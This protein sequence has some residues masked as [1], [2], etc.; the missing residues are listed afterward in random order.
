MTQNQAL[1][2]KKR[3]F[4]EDVAGYAFISPWLIC[5]FA[6]S[7]IPIVFSL[8]FSFTDYDILA[9][10]VF[11]GLKNFRRMA[12]DE[13]F[14]KSLAVTFFYAFV[15]VP[16]RLVFAFIVAV[17]FKRA[18]RMIRLY[19]AAYYLPS[20][21]GGSIAVAV[22][23]RRL[24]LADGAINAVLQAVG[25]PSTVSWLGNPN[26]AIWTL[27]LLAAWQFG[28]SMLIFL[29]GLRQIPVTYYEAASID[30]A[31]PI[32]QFFNIT[33]PQMTSII[34]FNLIMQLINGFTVFTQAFV[35]SGGNGD[36]QN[37]TLVYAL[38]LYQ[39]AFKYYSMGYSSAMAWVLVLIIGVFTGVIFKTSD[40]WVFYES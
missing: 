22:M 13:L 2:R 38:Y 34:F 17:L 29:A 20:I 18:S 35:V 10:P 12:T 36:P 8:Y 26:T 9:S 15:S 28:S 6:F 31:S 24:F 25:I 37:S 33:L 7:I 3:Q 40:K 30:G 27:I 39:R 21:V 23:W 19:Q 4:M 5:F 11:S 32:K 14:W 1:L 16:S